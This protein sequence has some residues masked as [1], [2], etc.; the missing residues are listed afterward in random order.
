M[1]NKHLEYEFDPQKEIRNFAKHGINFK[2]AKEVFEDDHVI[3]APDPKH[4]IDEP[5]WFAVGR[6]REG[7]IITVWF[8]RR[9]ERIRIIG[10][11]PLRKG[12]KEYE[13]RK[14]SR[15]SQV[16]MD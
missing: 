4:S 8:T 15:L 7:S 14:I 1:Y 11:A 6:T 5:R 13:K 3:I 12:K 16:E 9:E 2:T 10:A